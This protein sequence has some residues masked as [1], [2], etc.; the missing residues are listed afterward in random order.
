MHILHKKYETG[1]SN[2][3]HNIVS[4]SY[5]I[6]TTNNLKVINELR[7]ERSPFCVNYWTFNW[8]K[9]NLHK[10]KKIKHSILNHLKV[11]KPQN[12]FYLSGSNAI[13]NVSQLISNDNIKIIWR[14]FY[15]FANSLLFETLLECWSF[16][17]ECVWN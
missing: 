1:N 2:L 4:F 11:D 15:V 6:Q 12:S 16:I 8:C 17:S 7:W 14:H 10:F 9:T 13:P 5:F 3:N